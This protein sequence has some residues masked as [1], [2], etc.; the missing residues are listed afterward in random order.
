[1]K[2]GQ[3]IA[4]AIFATVC[5]AIPQGCGRL[6]NQE[7]K[8]VRWPDKANDR[9]AIEITRAEGSDVVI[10]DVRALQANSQFVSGKAY[11]KYINGFYKTSSG[12]FYT[13]EFWFVLDKHKPYP[14]CYAT[15][16]TNKGSWVMWCHS[17]N[18]PTNIVEIGEFI[19]SRSS[20]EGGGAPLL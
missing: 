18:A 6:A 3:T 19:T 20:P 9:Y 11:W 15:I 13:N 1:M 14:K 10:P 5:L 12:S 8:L 2:R 7:W 16:S 4:L 17:H